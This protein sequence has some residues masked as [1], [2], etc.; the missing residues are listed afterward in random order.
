MHY[1]AFGTTERSRVA[2]R[3]MVA[4]SLNPFDRYD[5]Y[6]HVGQIDIHC[7]FA[8]SAGTTIGELRK[9]TES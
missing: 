1:V 5:A 8:H 9:I 2:H 7:T 6:Q 4:I 3:A